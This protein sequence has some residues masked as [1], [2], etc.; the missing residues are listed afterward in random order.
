MCVSSISAPALQ[1]NVA[2]LLSLLR[3]SAQLNLAAP[4]HFLL[5]GSVFTYRA[6][7]IP[8]TDG[9][10]S[11]RDDFSHSTAMPSSII[12]ILGGDG[13]DG[14]SLLVFT[15]HVLP[16][17][18]IHRHVLSCRI[19]NDFV[20]R[21]PN[22]ENKKDTRDLQVCCAVAAVAVTSAKRNSAVIM[23]AVLSCRR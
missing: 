9:R 23:A 6:P 18:N 14:D 17:Q 1:E 3:E 8:L 15:H 20:N 7:V 12:L 5:L 2:P 22:L 16:N 10:D 13:I 21:L 4:G 11:E 19:L